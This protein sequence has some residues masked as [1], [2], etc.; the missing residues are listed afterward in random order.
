MFEAGRATLWRRAQESSTQGM[1]AIASRHMVTISGVLRVQTDRQWWGLRKK[2]RGGVGQLLAELLTSLDAA[3]DHFGGFSISYGQCND[4]HDDP[5]RF[6]GQGGGETERRRAT[7]I[8]WT[9]VRRAWLNGSSDRPMTMKVVCI[10]RLRFGVAFHR[11][12]SS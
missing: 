1:G 4:S 2:T 8:L 10:R 7:R 6:V 11:P 5:G 3:V 9:R 12:S